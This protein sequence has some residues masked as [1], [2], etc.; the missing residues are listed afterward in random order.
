[1]SET[2][3]EVS[4]GEATTTPTVGSVND[5]ERSAKWKNIRED[6]YKLRL[7]EKERIFTAL[8]KTAEERGIKL[9]F[10]DMKDNK[11]VSNP[12]RAGQGRSN[13]TD[14]GSF[15]K[16]DL[17]NWMWLTVRTQ[18][19]ENQ[20]FIYIGLQSLEIDIAKGIKHCLFDRIA[21]GCYKTPNSSITRMN[22]RITDY[23]LP[24]NENDL[25]ALVQEVCEILGDVSCKK[26]VKCEGSVVGFCLPDNA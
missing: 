25:N 3:S 22:Y 9:D 17:T 16:Y 13:Y 26:C 11:V 19:E 8:K 2:N 6:Y 4:K 1:M 14:E 7:A 5:N 12:M 10:M 15:K 24:L 18:N 23:D 21:I 20:K